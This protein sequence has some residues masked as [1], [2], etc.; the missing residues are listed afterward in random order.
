MSPDKI[1][2]DVTDLIVEDVPHADIV[3]EI[4]ADQEEQP[5]DPHSTFLDNGL[6]VTR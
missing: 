2:M 4:E 5:S 3:V 6:G 1:G